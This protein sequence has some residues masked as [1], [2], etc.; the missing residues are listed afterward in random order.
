MRLRLWFH[1]CCLLT[2]PHCVFICTIH[3][4]WLPVHTTDSIQTDYD[5]QNHRQLYWLNVRASN[6]LDTRSK[7]PQLKNFYSPRQIPLQEPLYFL[8]VNFANNYRGRCPHGFLFSS[9]QRLPLSERA[10]NNIFERLSSNLS[11]AAQDSLQ[12]CYMARTLGSHNLRHTSEKILAINSFIW[13]NFMN[14]AK[15]YP[16]K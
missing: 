13:C 11:P 15:N 8:I 1:W 6:L 14:N 5:Y 12:K 10:L 9:Q 3:I 7:K 2:F 16:V 4:T